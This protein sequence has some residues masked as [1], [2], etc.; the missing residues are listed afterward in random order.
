MFFI[1]TA[2]IGLLAVCSGHRWYPCNSDTSVGYGIPV[3]FGYFSIRWFILAI[4]MFMSTYFAFVKHFQMDAFYTSTYTT[5]AYSQSLPFNKWFS[6]LMFCHVVSGPFN[7]ANWTWMFWSSQISTLRS[8]LPFNKWFSYCT[9]L[10]RCVWS[11]YL[12]T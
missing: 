1:H 4:Y 7:T 8:S 3:C 2:C 12:W 11:L 6:Y 9:F 10:P 5:P